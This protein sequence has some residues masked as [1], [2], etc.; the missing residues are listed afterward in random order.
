M[1]MSTDN[2]TSVFTMFR[3]RLRGV[4]AAIVGGESADD[5]M[6][7]AFC[8]LWARQR[9]VQDEAEAMKLSYAAVRNAAIDSFRRSQSH[10]TMSLETVP[11]T[12]DV[13]DSSMC[14]DRREVYEAVLKL[15]GEVLSPRAYRIFQLH[16]IEGLGYDEVAARMSLTEANIRVILSRSRKTI[17]EIYLRHSKDL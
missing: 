2:L 8:R 5:V 1:S 14:D 9:E 3:L 17:R 10:P 7:D 11:Q 12:S 13:A 4:A 15:A 6:Q 16:D